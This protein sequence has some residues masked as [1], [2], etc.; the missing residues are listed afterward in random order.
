VNIHRRDVSSCNPRT[1]CVMS[2]SHHV[3]YHRIPSTQPVVEN[4][5][6]NLNCLFEHCASAED[7]A[8][9]VFIACY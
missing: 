2:V 8:F 7:V 1:C 4:S 3:F 5:H 9:F 6:Y